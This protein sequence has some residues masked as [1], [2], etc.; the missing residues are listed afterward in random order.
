MT[1]DILSLKKVITV[2]EDGAPQI[3]GH[4]E[5]SLEIKKP[6]ITVGLHFSMENRDKSYSK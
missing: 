4:N 3:M 6:W 5:P 1:E 2:R